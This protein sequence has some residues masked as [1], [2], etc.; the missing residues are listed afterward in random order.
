MQNNRLTKR[1][2]EFQ[3]IN[4][5]NST[6]FDNLYT[7]LEKLNKTH[8]IIEGREVDVNNIKC[9]LSDLMHEE[10]SSTICHKPKLR[11]YVKFKQD[12][13][14]EE[15]VTINISRSQR[16]LL[17]QLRMGILPLNIETGR[18]LR[19]TLNERLCLLCNQNTIEDE[20]HFL[21]SCPVYNDERTNFCQLISGFENLIPDEQLCHLMKMNAKLVVQYIECIWNKR[22]QF[23]LEM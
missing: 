18:Y 7:I 5:N 22:K 3:L 16:S 2:A 19:K 4:I 8:Y 1:I 20:F 12:I 6:W 23:Y 21:F 9:E 10:W 14:V 11:N 15:Y 17:A 13:N